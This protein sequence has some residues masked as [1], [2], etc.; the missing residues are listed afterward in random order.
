[1]AGPRPADGPGRALL[2]G[3][4]LDALEEIL[5]LEHDA[6]RGGALHG[7]GHLGAEG[8]LEERRRRIVAR[9]LRT[10]GGAGRPELASYGRAALGGCIL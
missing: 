5:R 10:G 9:F 6:C 1:M 3:A 8:S 2:G 4:C 7:L